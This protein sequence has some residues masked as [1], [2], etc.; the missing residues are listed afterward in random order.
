MND[1]QKT[2]GV[3]SPTPPRAERSAAALVGQYIHEL[4]GRH[5]EMRLRA[6]PPHYGASSPTSLIPGDGS[7]EAG[8]RS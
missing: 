2:Q 7:P 8:G 5:G 1:A 6:A 4:S 3:A